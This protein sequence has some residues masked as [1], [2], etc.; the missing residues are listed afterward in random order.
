MLTKSSTNGII[1]ILLDFT[2]I[3]LPMPAIRKLNLGKRQR[4]ALIGIFAVGGL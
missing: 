4:G 1:N 3:I 2:I